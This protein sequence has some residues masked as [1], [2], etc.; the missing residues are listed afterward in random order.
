MNR[1]AG[2]ADPD[3]Q[4]PRAKRQRFRSDSGPEGERVGALPVAVGN[5]V[6]AVARI[7][8]IAVAAVASVTPVLARSSDQRVVA[9][10]TDQNVVAGLAIE[11]VVECRVSNKKI[12]VAGP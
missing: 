4:R 7:E 2:G 12:V 5:D 9:G 10:G 3:Q 11:S 1:I 8:Y 6:D